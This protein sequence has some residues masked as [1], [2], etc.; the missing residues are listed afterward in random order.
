MG[1]LVPATSPRNL[2]SLFCGLHVV[3]ENKYVVPA[4]RM[5][6]QNTALGIIALLLK[7]ALHKNASLFKAPQ[8][9][10]WNI[11]AYLNVL[12]EIQLLCFFENKNMLFP[13]SFLNYMYACCMHQTDLKQSTY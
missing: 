12:V 6:I 11:E 1:L 10:I 3:V 4:S 13:M 5:S 9:L 7:S 8:L 2:T